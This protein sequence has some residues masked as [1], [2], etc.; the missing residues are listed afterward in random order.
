MDEV[1]LSRIYTTISKLHDASDS[2]EA[3]QTFLHGLGIGFEL[4]R[5]D[6]MPANP[7]CEPGNDLVSAA[8]SLAE[9]IDRLYAIAKGVD[10]DDE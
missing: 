7:L 8:G 5:P 1:T 10:D 6:T 3:T 2:I 4:M 9:A